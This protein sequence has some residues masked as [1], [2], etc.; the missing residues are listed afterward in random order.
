MHIKDIIKDPNRQP[1]EDVQRVWS[2]RR[3]SMEPSVPVSW[4]ALPSQAWLV[5]SSAMGD[6]LNPQPPHHQEEEGWDPKFQPS[7]LG[8]FGD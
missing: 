3:P 5:K 4:V 2:G 6:E 7:N 8:L 1:D